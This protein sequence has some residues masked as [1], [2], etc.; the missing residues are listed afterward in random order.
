MAPPPRSYRG[1]RWTSWRTTGDGRRTSYQAGPE[2]KATVCRED[3]EEAVLVA[4]E[5]WAEERLSEEE[6]MSDWWTVRD[7]K[8]EGLAMVAT[9]ATSSQSGKCTI[10]I[11][12]GFPRE[13][14]PPPQS[15][16]NIERSTYN[17]ASQHAILRLSLTVILYGNRYIYTM[18]FA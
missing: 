16:V 4:V 10:F 8:A 7:N 11:P 6:Q 13:L 12:S 9:A 18:C 1:G 14:E 3:V 5:T 2:K 17:F 15:V